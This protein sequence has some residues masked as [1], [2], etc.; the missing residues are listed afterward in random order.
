MS[1]RSL[2]RQAEQNDLNQPE[3]QNLLSPT[4]RVRVIITKQALQEGWDCSFAY[5]LC[6][7]AANSNMIAMTQLVG[8]ILRQP[9]AV[10][11]GV[12]TLDECHIITHHADTAIAVAAIK[13]GLEGDGLG[14]L[15]LQMSYDNISENGMFKRKTDRRPAYALT[16]IYL[17]KVITMDGGEARELDYETDVL[18]SIDWRGFNPE[19]IANRIPMNAQAAERQFTTD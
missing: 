13:E 12:P 19:D 7:L 8:R 11:T 14:D 1:R 2:S 16:E 18:S 15:V 6:S 17:P 9:E 10:K 3:N 4:N 5:I